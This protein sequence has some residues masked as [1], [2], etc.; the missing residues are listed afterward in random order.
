MRKLHN[1]AYTYF[2]STKLTDDTFFIF[3]LLAYVPVR[4]IIFA[5]QLRFRLVGKADIGISKSSKP[6]GL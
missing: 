2:K 5:S 4:K 3:I 6:D 1:R